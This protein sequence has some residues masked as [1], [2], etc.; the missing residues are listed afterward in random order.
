MSCARR[1][2][3]D[4]ILR[5]LKP[6]DFEA[7]I[8]PE[9]GEVRQH[10]VNKQCVIASLTDPKQKSIR[11]QLLTEIKEAKRLVE[12]SGVNTSQLVI[13][14]T[15]YI[16]DFASE[17]GFGICIKNGTAFIYNGQYWIPMDKQDTEVFL[18]QVAVKLGLNKYKAEYFKFVDELYKQFCLSAASTAPFSE[19]S[20]SVLINCLNGT[21]E[22]NEGVVALRPFDNADFLKYQ[23]GFNYDPSLAAPQF[24]SFLDKVLPDVDCQ[25]LLAEYIGYVF[26]KNGKLKLEQVM[27]LYGGGHNGKSVFFDII[28]ALFGKENVS[29]FSPQELFRENGGSANRAVIANKLLNYSSEAGNELNAE[30]FKKMAS[31]E[32]VTARALYGHPFEVTDYAKLMFNANQLPQAPEMTP[33]FYRRLIIMPFTVEILASERDYG[34]AQKIIS[35]ELSG[36]LNWALNGLSRLLKNKKL[37]FAAVSDSYLKEYQTESDSVLLFMQE[38]SYQPSEIWMPLFE[39]YGE[40]SGFCSRNGYKAISAKK[41]AQRLRQAGVRIERKSMGNAVFVARPVEELEKLY[42]EELKDNPYHKFQPRAKR[43]AV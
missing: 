41:V 28:N 34:L 12:K 3:T 31:G 21:L 5:L 29:C 30:M 43:V 35:M 2:V 42:Q 8:Y 16:V 38:Y 19:K 13:A 18:M 22:I 10:L 17:N 6:V 11:Q 36:V 1:K 40:Y 39:F 23:L 27:I 14:I 24:Q 9:V 25:S 33:A 7:I 4:E 37:T 20:D 32:P 26:L 15:D